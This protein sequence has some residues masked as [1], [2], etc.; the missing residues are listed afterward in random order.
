MGGGGDGVSGWEEVGWLWHRDSFCFFSVGFSVVFGEPL[1]VSFMHTR[2][3]LIPPLRS[4]PPCAPVH[5][6]LIK[7]TLSRVRW[8]NKG[9][10]GHNLTLSQEKEAPRCMFAC[11]SRLCWCYNLVHSWRK[12]ACLIRAQPGTRVAFPE[13]FRLTLWCRKEVITDTFLCSLRMLFKIDI[14]SHLYFNRE[15]TIISRW[16]NL[17]SHNSNLQKENIKKCTKC[18]F[19]CVNEFQINYCALF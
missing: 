2:W 1:L 6:L 10:V 14:T 17:K 18:V 19:I 8:D 9:K 16:T 15:V 13:L 7:S 3:K 12:Q 11:A 4:P 5:N